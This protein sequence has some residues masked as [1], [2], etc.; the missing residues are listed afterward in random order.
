MNGAVPQDLL[1]EIGTEELPANAQASL[2]EALGTAL[3]A[4]LRERGIA[5]ASSEV[6]STPRRLA[7]LA[8]AIAAIGPERRHERRGPS[9][10]AAFGADGEPTRAAEGFAR[11]AGVAVSELATLRS[12][13]GEWLVHRHVEPGRA[14][15]DVLAEILPGILAGL[16]LKRRMRWGAGETS[17]LRPVRWLV[18]RYG[19]RVIPIEAFGLTAGGASRGHRFHHP[20]PV[21]I[22]APGDYAAALQT[23]RVI[24]DSATRLA[25]VERQV[26][27][28]AREAGGRPAAPPGL[29]TEIAGMVEW[30]VAVT[31]EFDAK[32]LELPEAVLIT[33]LA[34]H[35]RFV[36]IRDGGGKL[37]TRF[38]AVMNLE[39]QAPET[40][41]EGLER[42]VRPRLED[43]AFYY[44]RDREQSLA[45]YAKALEDLS[46]GEKL[47]SMAEKS[48]RLETLA[49]AIAQAIGTDADTAARAARLAKCD[50]VTG[51]VFEFPEL[52]GIMGGH[53]AAVD[54]E[55]RAVAEAIAEQYLPAGAE[56][57]LPRTPIG[58]ALA[59]ADRLDTLVGGFA[60]GR[61]PTGTRDP[62]GLRRA[63]FGLLRI[64]AEC[65]PELELTTWFERAA[66]GYPA[67]LEAAR[68][69]PALEEFLRERLRSM[70]LERG[71][72]TDL[73]YA[74]LAVAPLRPAEIFNRAAAVEAFR[75]RPEAE[76]LAAANKRI[77]N[78]LRQA[79]EIPTN[80]PTTK[81]EVPPAEAALAQALDGVLPEL[82]RRLEKRD[83]NAALSLL[84]D[85]RT[86]VDRFFDGVLVMDPDPGARARRLQLLERLH[87]SFLKVADV[88][89]LQGK[90]EK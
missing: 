72:S 31:A 10:A 51:M 32:Y 66:A 43:A 12:E 47:G 53:Y 74:V 80:T 55:D 50:L 25:E 24:A 28:R 88:A 89:K 86:A 76:A 69:L 75:R 64:A 26:A 9:L 20:E 46:F 44:R 57:E 85:L 40:L 83:F 17:F 71:Y 19:N 8:R 11:S 38:I 5:P 1:I 21:A 61:Q 48:A 29:F 90:D 79:G 39:S 62:F 70:L 7:V 42:V 41:R 54:G 36:P 56:D 87:S 68:D 52:Q 81:A 3:D 82:D 73:V 35:Q 4:V 37:S 58:T 67:A 77:A 15:P 63:A 16:A 27:E 60:G 45:G 33:T 59:L 84:A 65:A 23:G 78:I 6:F 49:A 22:E 14:T 30:P 18:V 2:A 34:H 13:Q